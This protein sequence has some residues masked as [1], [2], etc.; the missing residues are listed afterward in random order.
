VSL[1][2]YFEEI[3][4]TQAEA[5]RLARE[6]TPPGTFVVARRQTAGRGRSTHSWASPPGGLYLSAIV[7][8]PGSRPGLV[9]LAVAERLRGHMEEAFGVQSLL[10]WPN[11]LLVPSEKS[12][13]RKLAGVL[14]DRVDAQVA[15]VG[16]GVNVSSR[17]EDFP[18][19]IQDRVAILRE[20]TSYPPDVAQVESETVEIIHS[21][22]ELLE[23]E[24]GRRAILSACRR[25]LFGRGRAARVDGNPVGVI[26]DLG[27]DGELWV[28]GQQGRQAVWAGDLTVEG[29]G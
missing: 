5:V 28:E 10:K 18:R 22:L 16:V 29:A 19:E 11:D 21:T 13:L 6:G 9:P 4:S 17:R 15:V 7:G 26:R 3:P 23:S 2:R 1:R 14:V 8:L 20:L 24:A 12:A 27:D 25:S